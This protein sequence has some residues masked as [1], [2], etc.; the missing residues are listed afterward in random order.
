MPIKWSDNQHIDRAASSIIGLY[1]TALEYTQEHA[2]T[3]E[4][5]IV[6]VVARY[7]EPPD[8]Y[9]FCESLY[10]DMTGQEFTDEDT[11]RAA[12]RLYEIYKR[13]NP[14]PEE[15]SSATKMDA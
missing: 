1:R 5:A 9:L 14:L 7:M 6:Q 10:K 3:I 15:Q 2:C 11:T 13:N 4:D 8:M 12:A